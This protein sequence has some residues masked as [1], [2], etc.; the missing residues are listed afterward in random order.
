MCDALNNVTNPYYS[1]NSVKNF[2][3]GTDPIRIVIIIYIFLSFILNTIIFIT[4][5]FTIKLRKI[6]F[7]METWIML[8]VLLMN[9]FHTF[10]YFFQWVIKDDSIQMF[11]VDIN[12]RKIN[13]GA[14]LTG[15][16]KNIFGCT[17]QGYLLISTSISQDFL[18]NIFFS[19]V[20]ATNINEQRTK[21]LLLVLG[22]IFPFLFTLFLGIFEG[23]G[24]NDEFCYVK[25]FEYSEKGEC[26]VYKYYDNFQYVVMAVYAIRVLNFIVTAFFLKR[27]WTFVRQKN[28]PTI[29][30]MKSIFI[31]IIQLV[32]VFI[33]V[34]YRLINAF[35]PEISQKLSGVY[36]ILNTVDGVLFPIGFA[37]QNSLIMQIKKLIQGKNGNQNKEDGQTLEFLPSKDDDG[38]DTT[39]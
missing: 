20:N 19:L 6:K 12:G 34:A 17:F 29:Y 21:I 37:F 32:T 35:D 13:V 23:I 27:I 8:S 38:L 5:G 11:E 25:K 26:L 9:F 16:P 15:N 2:F 39:D 28:K 36:L 3:G 33:G 10:A 31:P 18:I 1:I 4:I 14:L 24:I 7:P 22:I 30:L